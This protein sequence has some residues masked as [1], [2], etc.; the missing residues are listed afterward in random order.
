MKP[1]PGTHLSRQQHIFNY[2]LSRSRRLIE[3]CFGIMA[4]RFRI[5]QR[6]IEVR[7]NFVQDIVL[8]TCIL[9]NFLRREGRAHYI[10][11]GSV[12][13]EM[14]DG[15]VVQGDW[16]QDV[17]E[18]DSVERDRQRNPTHYAKKV[19]NRLSDYFLTEEGEVPWQYD[20]Y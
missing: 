3:N 6:T 17:L 8:A 11:P 19:R 2:R 5:F 20:L 4:S 18:L 7:P 15:S 16:R 13:Q 9:H 1:F 14:A 12:D 10:G